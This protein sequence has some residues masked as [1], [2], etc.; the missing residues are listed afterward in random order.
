MDSCVTESF[1]S[2]TKHDQDLYFP[3]GNV[4]LYVQDKEGN[5]TNFRL[6]KSILAKHSAVFHDMFSMPSP[7]TP[8][9]TESYDG[10]PLVELHDEPEDLKTFLMNLYEPL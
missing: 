7:T 2:M 5:S 9:E 3:D 1:R 6:H 8:V 4:V 10:V